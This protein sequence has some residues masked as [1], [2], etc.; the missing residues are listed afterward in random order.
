MIGFWRRVVVAAFTLACASAHAQWRTYEHVD[1]MTDKVYRVA[2]NFSSDGYNFGIFRAPDGAV[3][4]SIGVPK[5]NLV[6][7]DNKAVLI[8][9][10]RHAALPQSPQSRE[11]ARLLGSMWNW[12]P[13][14]ITTVIWH[15]KE[16][17]GRNDFINQ[18]MSS[19]QALV[20][21]PLSGGGTQDISFSMEGA[22]SAI[23]QA[24]NIPEVAD[25]AM[26]ARATAYRDAFANEI[27][28]CNISAN[29]G[30]CLQRLGKCHGQSGKD[31]AN[32]NA[33]TAR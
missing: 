1:A 11:M 25:P 16:S 12:T 20:R 2:T 21:I 3:W 10:D 8:R 13:K 6:L 24:L 5:E 29:R 7:L 27:D 32:L 15:G 33:C 28:K 9:F 31:V 18:A 22:R 30:Q 17:D 14:S 4:M 19:S 23:A 26:E